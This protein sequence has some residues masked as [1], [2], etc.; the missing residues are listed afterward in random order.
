MTL[1][2]G[3]VPPT[4]SGLLHIL[5]L[6][7]QKRLDDYHASCS[8]RRI[9]WMKSSRLFLVGIAIFSSSGCHQES[10][11][12]VEPVVEDQV[13][14]GRVFVATKGGQS[15][16]LGSVAVHV[17]PAVQLPEVLIELAPQFES[18][19]T[20][21][22]SDEDLARFHDEVNQVQSGAMERYSLL[23]GDPQEPSVFEEEIRQL[24]TATNSLAEEVGEGMLSLD[25]IFDALELGFGA[26]NPS[27]LT[28]SDGSF[29]L[30][31]PGDVDNVIVVARASRVVSTKDTE[32]YHWMVGHK[33]RQGRLLLTNSNIIWDVTTLTDLLSEQ[34]PDFFT[35]P[36]LLQSRVELDRIAAAFR[37]ATDQWLTDAV[38]RIEE[39]ERMRLAEEERARAE[40]ARLAELERKRQEVLTNRNR[41]KG[42]PMGHIVLSNDAKSQLKAVVVQGFSG[43]GVTVF[44]SGGAA[45]ISWD[46][47]PASWR[48]KYFLFEELDPF[49]SH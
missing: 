27:V 19:S 22:V 11:P 10:P 15:Y 37:N 44:H 46:E 28:D 14:S 25:A 12:A 29:E 8:H 48:E 35:P 47:V 1:P 30:K 3:L 33:P 34:V 36:E 49:R 43:K 32:T 38:T 24:A 23:I 20:W 6:F 40:A 26:H 21:L 16:K 5:Q 39:A 41:D 4:D 45:T 13:I 42:A 2:D 17:L 18:I 31:L 9:H 7:H